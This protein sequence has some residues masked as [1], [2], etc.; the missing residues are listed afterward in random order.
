MVLVAAEA[1]PAGSKPPAAVSVRISTGNRHDFSTAVPF[2]T[3]AS[4]LEQRRA[5]GPV[6]S[7]SKLVRHIG[8]GS[9]WFAEQ[10]SPRFA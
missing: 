1:V 2:P 6:E 5:G 10:L 3:R 9:T 4:S 7:S 8:S